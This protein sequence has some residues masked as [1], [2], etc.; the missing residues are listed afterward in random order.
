MTG[1]ERIKVCLQDFSHNE[2]TDHSSEY[3]IRINY[4][5]C[6]LAIS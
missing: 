4:Q 2:D 5:Y 1:Y 6:T 3:T